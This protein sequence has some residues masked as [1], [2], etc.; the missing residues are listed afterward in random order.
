MPTDPVERYKQFIRKTLAIAGVSESIE[1]KVL[2]AVGL[3]F[4][5]SVALALVSVVTGGTLQLLLTGA[6]LAGAVVAFANTVF[7]TREDLVEPVVAMSESADHIAAGELDAD[8]PESDRDDEV[9]SLLASFRSMH[10]YLETVSEQADALSRQEFDA[11]VLDEDVP[12]TFG[13]SLERMAASMDDYTTELQAMTSDLER[14]SQALNDLVVAFG[15]AAERAKDGDLTATIDEEFAAVDDEQFEAVVENYNDLVTTLGDTVGTVAAFADEVDDTSDHVTRSVEEIDDA[16]DEI[17]R[18]VQEISAGASQ[19]SDRHADVASEMNT[20]SATVEEIAATAEN[21]ADTAEKAS[22]RGREG[23]ADA[24]A[25]ID[26]L[27]EME[28]R[29]GDIAASV[30]SLGDQIGEIDEIVEVITDI[31]EQTNMLALN[32]SIEAARADGEGDGFAVVADEVK[33]LAEETHDAAT[34]VSNRIE[35]VQAEATETVTDVE[36]TNQQVTDSVETIESALR[37]FEDIVDV[38]GEVNDSIQEISEAT[39]EQSDTTQEVVD[40]V[41]EVASVSE[42]TSSESESVA[43]ATEE[44][45]ATI[46][47]VT[48]EVQAMA[49]RTD[50]L[51]DVLDEFEVADD[52]IGTSGAVDESTTVPADD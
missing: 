35:S 5:A 6:L 16:S 17:A 39:A 51:Q 25:A 46:T 50:D 49:S 28:T 44:Q 33:T 7:I 29:I 32:A 23:R 45:T 21:A 20:L 9:A 47:E 37:D 24:E 3:Q 19:Q 8:L 30:E 27:D 13:R 15:E 41:D 38:L 42:Q 18:S 36:A 14:R 40:M 11:D 48:D 2:A 43:A 4:A 10:A 26:E 12:G 52:A 34:D 22:R 1:R 31:A